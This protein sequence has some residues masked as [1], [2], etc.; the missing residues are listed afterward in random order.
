[1]W[2]EGGGLCGVSQQQREIPLGKGGGGG[3]GRWLLGWGSRFVG[4]WRAVVIG[5]RGAGWLCCDGG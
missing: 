3:K 5:E 1:M 2:E 4:G